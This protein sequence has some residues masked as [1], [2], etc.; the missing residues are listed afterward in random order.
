[1]AGKTYD[2]I[3]FMNEFDLLE[4]RLKTLD[5]VVDYFVIVEAPWTFSGK[6]KP[7]YFKEFHYGYKEWLPKIRHIQLSGTI[8]AQ[9]AWE[10]EW[11][12]RNAMI[13]GLYDA[14]PDDWVF[15]SD[16]DEIWRPE[17]RD[18]APDAKIATYDMVHS[19][20]ALNTVRAPSG[21]WAG[22]R[23]CKFRDWPGGQKL[24][25]EVGF[26]IKNA[27]WHFS[28]L[29]DEHQAST[30]LQAFSHTEYG[31]PEYADPAK[32]REHMDAGT[33]LITPLQAF[34]VPVEVDSTFPKPVVEDPE[35]WKKFIK[36]PV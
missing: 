31:T 13:E 19:F 2:T 17:L 23:R 26:R 36:I 11:A 29:G 9:I 24:R 3:L 16:T 32:I 14:D 22:S 10:R 12:S 34:Y 15:Q 33:D 25:D 5:P 30:K 6:P 20:Y 18:E 4:L 1:M 7:C 21:W 8:N 27:G 28:F 35:R